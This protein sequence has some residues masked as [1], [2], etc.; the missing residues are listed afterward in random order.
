MKRGKEATCFRCGDRDVELFD[1]LDRLIRAGV[2]EPREK[3]P[4]GGADP[5]FLAGLELSAAAPGDLDFGA[6]EW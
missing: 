1:L 2:S 5:A 4:G 6:A 3:L